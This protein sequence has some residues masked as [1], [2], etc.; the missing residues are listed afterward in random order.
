VQRAWDYRITGRTR[1]GGARGPVSAFR[2]ASITG[3]DR[4]HANRGPSVFGPCYGF[5]IRQSYTSL[6]FDLDRAEL[7]PGASNT[8]SPVVDFLND[9]PEVSVRITGHTC[10][11]G[12]NEHNLDLS[13]RRA[14]AV[15]DYL[16]SRGID[17]DRLFKAAEGESQPI[18]TNLT[19]EG[20]RSNRRVEV[21]QL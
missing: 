11:L 7:K 2:G 5:C 8:L 6:Q 20:R 18:D 16:V 13:Q 14:D 1:G 21:L 10:W 12:S 9:Y 3:H 17:R 4:W 19:E 15:G